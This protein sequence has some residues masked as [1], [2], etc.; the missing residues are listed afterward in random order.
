MSKL[1]CVF[2][3]CALRICAYVYVCD[4]VHL[5]VSISSVRSLALSHYFLSFFLQVD[6]PI[7][8]VIRFYTNETIA[9]GDV[10]SVVLPGFG[11]G[12]PDFSPTVESF[13]AF[14]RANR[15]CFCFHLVA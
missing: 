4:Q 1:Y 10:I 3:S 11:A 9:Q 8:L 5:F 6:V 12:R 13:S 15:V 2:L 14:R 7:D